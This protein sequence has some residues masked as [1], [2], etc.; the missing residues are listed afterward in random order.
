MELKQVIMNRRSIRMYQEK[1]IDAEDILEIL[2]AGVNAPSAVNYQ[3]WYF[4]VIKSAEKMTELLGI[5][6]DVAKVSEE[7]LRKAFPNRP[8]VAEDT[9]RFI[10]CLGGAPVC[11]LTFKHRR[12]YGKSSATV[13]Q[14]VAAAIENMILTATDKGIG[15]CW[16]TAGTESGAG[17]LI[18]EKF[19]PDKGELVALVTLGFS[20]QEPQAPSRKDDRYIII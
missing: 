2:E 19:A 3:P 16:L 7:N 20:A 6:A 13:T 17:D 11:V 18:R 15:S 5:M 8:D 10:R 14:S 4:V 1:M 12:D 9:G